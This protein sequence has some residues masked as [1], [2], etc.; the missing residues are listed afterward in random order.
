MVE[1]IFGSFSE[2]LQLVFDQRNNIEIHNTAMVC[3]ALW[4]NRNDLV[5]T[6]KSLD[7]SEVLM[8][9]LSVLNQWRFVQDK[10]FDHSLGF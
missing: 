3:W 8:L 9:A 10:S 2:W 4:K 1:G 5:W 6:Q 7:S